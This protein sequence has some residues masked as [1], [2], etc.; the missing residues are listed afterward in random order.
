[1]TWE[2]SM[3]RKV[4]RIFGVLLA[5]VLLAGNATVVRA[6]EGITGNVQA[7]SVSVTK[8][9]LPAPTGAAWGDKWKMDWDYLAAYDDGTEVV[10]C[11]ELYKDGKYINFCMGGSKDEIEC[12]FYDSLIFGGNGDYKFRIRRQADWDYDDG[13]KHEGDSDWS[14][15]SNIKSYVKPAGK[16]AT[17]TIAWDEEQEG[18][19]V[20]T[21]TGTNH[22]N[23][24]ILVEY[25]DGTFFNNDPNGFYTGAI[26]SD[27]FDLFEV[28]DWMGAGKYKVRVAACTED[29]DT[30]CNSDFSGY[31]TVWEVTEED[32]ED[33]GDDEG[34]GDEDD[35]AEGIPAEEVILNETELTLNKGKKFQLTATMNPED[36]TDEIW[37]DSSDEDVAT[38]SDDGLV[39]AK[40]PGTATI[41]AMADSGEEATCEVTVKLPSTRIKLNKTKATL[42][43]G[44]KLALKAVVTPANHTDELKWKSDNEK[45]ASVS[46]KGI[47]KAL[48]PGTAKITVTTESGKKASCIVTVES[49]AIKVTLSKK[50]L[51]I[52]VG[53]TA[54]LK[55]TMTPANS[56][57]KLTWKSSNKKV[58]TVTDKG[59]VKGIKKGNAIITVTT[60]SKKKAT[61]KVTVK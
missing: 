20:C 3:R 57:D 51:E 5:V 12:G 43:I 54:S 8:A 49:P 58:A 56:T 13:L 26:E 1:M 32:I 52:K 9:D 42:K 40:G 24:N 11:A 6:E 34:D 46:D 7:K 10:L 21:G 33:D 59:I 2:N 27:T 44:K 25:A 37:W 45:V 30:I 4:M 14:E 55:A 38:V 50:K 23:Y 53:K 16:L 29:P 39:T 18:M 19:V 35:E 36:S 22:F 48:K 60:S 17:P 15:F 41:T 28:I 31:T 61:C 47:V